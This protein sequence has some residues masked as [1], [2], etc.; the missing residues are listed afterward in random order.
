MLSLRR[1]GR[2]LGAANNLRSGAKHQTPFNAV[3]RDESA[4]SGTS[5]T[6]VRGVVRRQ[7]KVSYL[8]DV[9]GSP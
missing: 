2:L 5:E 1:L 6:V 3:A 7:P 9:F 8:V 4:I